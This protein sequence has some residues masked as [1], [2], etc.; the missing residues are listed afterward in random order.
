[1]FWAWRWPVLLTYWQYFLAGIYFT[2]LL[3]G[4]TLVASMAIGIVGAWIQTSRFA[5]PRAF[6]QGYVQLFRNTPPLVQL[7][8]FFFIL[9][10]LGLRLSNFGCAVISLSL[11]AGAFNVEIFRAGIEA[12][13]RTTIESLEALA[14][15]RFQQYWLVI[16]PLAFRISLP[17]LGNNLVNLV[18]ATSQASAIAV[19]ELLYR[20]IEVY[21]HSFATREVM[22]LI[23]AVYVALVGL[24]VWALGRWER[25]IRMPGMG[26]TRA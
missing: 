23:W 20:A 11:F 10:D 2:C 19:P 16:L 17:A 4:I 15:S 6:V 9:P 13:P 8:F 24:L 5:L 7:F 1:M 3:A 12:V 22:I 14:F 25:R 26:M 21:T 18:K